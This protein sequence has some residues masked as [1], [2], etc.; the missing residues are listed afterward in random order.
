MLTVSHFFFIITEVRD[1]KTADAPM[2]FLSKYTLCMQYASYNFISYLR[3]LSGATK[4]EFTASRQHFTPI[5]EQSKY[6]Y[7]VYVD[8]HCAACR[9]GFMM[10]LGSV[11][12]K[13][14]PRQ[15]ADRMWYFPLLKPYHDHVPVQA[16]LSDL[17][18]KIQ[19]CREPDD[20]CRQIGE[21]A[22]RFYEKYVGIKP[23]LDYLEMV[24]KNIAKRFV[25]PPSWW[26][27]PPPEQ[28]P[29]KL[30]KPDVPCYEDRQNGGRLCT[31]CQE[32]ADAELQELEQAQAQQSNA[33]EDQIT[34]RKRLR[35]RMKK[36]S[37]DKKKKQS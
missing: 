33:K 2:S 29:P 27:A 5:Y 6:K 17:D 11:I 19:W 9:Y 25:D 13:V 26:V 23:T 24:C 1:K 10:R 30:R 18:E 8:V 3:F 14:E 16:D 34:K 20:K 35:E 21:N 36:I 31:R 37:A 28:T 22:K 32:D 7:L 4:F 15:V 12:L